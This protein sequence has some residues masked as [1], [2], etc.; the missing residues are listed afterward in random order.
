M[1][2]PL[3]LVYCFSPPVF[4]V[5]RLILI[6]ILN[7]SITQRFLKRYSFFVLFI[8]TAGV[9]LLQ[10]GVDRAV[11]PYLRVD[12]FDV[13]QGDAI[14]FQ[15][16][17]R[18]QV[19]IDGGPR[20]TVIE[21]L[22]RVMPFWDRTIDLV[23]LTHPQQDHIGGLIGVLDRYDVKQIMLSGV[24]YSLESYGALLEII[25][26]KHVPVYFVRGGERFVFD[27]GITATLLN[28]DRVIVGETSKQVNE[29]SLV[30]RLEYGNTSFLFT[31]DAG[32]AAERDMI[33]DGDMIGAD[34]L[35]VGHHGSRYASSE[36]FL[37][38]V[39]PQ[40][41]VIQVS[42]DNRY[43]HPTDETLR[44][45]AAIGAEVLRTDQDGDIRITSDG[46]HIVRRRFGNCVFVC[47]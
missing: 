43:G 38:T 23:V 37:R 6:D 13:G 4:K 16:P 32:F 25:K 12:F 29:T 46:V 26:K 27:S 3:V 31:G 47:R 42:R 39:S 10:Q 15:T 41:A 33:A 36:S 45:L 34:V 19:L 8:L 28:P 44:R 9:L 21:K 40:L 17:G 2:H 11:S 35:K 5:R 30:M 1:H 24:R 22:A 7:M 14:F 18:A 20:N